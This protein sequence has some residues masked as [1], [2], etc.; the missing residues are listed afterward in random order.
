MTPEE[1]AEPSTAQVPQ[2]PLVT[3]AECIDEIEQPLA[4]TRVVRADNG[5]RWT[6]RD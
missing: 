3:A 4:D 2:Q 6:P 5:V 1:G